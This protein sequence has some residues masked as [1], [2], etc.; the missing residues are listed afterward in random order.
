M[1]EIKKIL[2]ALDFSQASRHVTEYALILAKSLGAELSFLYVAPTLRRYAAYQIETVS[3][4][5]FVGEIVT[6]AQKE[7]DRFLERTSEEYEKVSGTVAIGY[8]PDVIIETA[9]EQGADMVVMGTHGRKGIDSIIFGSV[10]EKVLKMSPLPV[11][12]IRPRT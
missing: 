6:G 2:C 12:T 4:E 1:A 10:A 9:L 3:I 5:N 7:M 8:A 11:L